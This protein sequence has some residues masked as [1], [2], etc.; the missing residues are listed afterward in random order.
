MPLLFGDFHVQPKRYTWK[1]KKNSQGFKG[2]DNPLS[3]K[4]DSFC[5]IAPNSVTC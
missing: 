1:Q 4:Q 3:E 2:D 5:L